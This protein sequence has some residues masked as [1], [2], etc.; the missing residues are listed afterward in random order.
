MGRWEKLEELTRKLPAITTHGS[1]DTTEYFSHGGPI[2]GFN[3]LKVEDIAVQKAHMPDGSMIAVHDHDEIEHIIVYRGGLIFTT[4]DGEVTVKVGEVITFQPGEPH[5]A[6]AKGDTW[7]IG[8][9]IPASKGYPGL[10]DKGQ[11]GLR[12]DKGDRGFK[13][14][15]GIRGDKGERGDPGASD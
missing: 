1:S 7:M 4:K 10:I 5:S 13:G 3:L 2:T 15:P 14:D 8:I 9:T 11:K 12:G 6:I